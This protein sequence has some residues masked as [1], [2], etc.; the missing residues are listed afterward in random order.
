MSQDTPIRAVNSLVRSRRQF[1][2]L[3]TRSLT[4][5]STRSSTHSLTNLDMSLGSQSNEKVQGIIISLKRNLVAIVEVKDV[6]RLG[7]HRL[8]TVA[9]PHSSFDADLHLVVVVLVLERLALELAEE[10]G[11]Q[12][13]VRRSIRV[14]QVAEVRVVAGNQRQLRCGRVLLLSLFD[15]DH[16]HGETEWWWLGVLQV[17]GG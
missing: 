3:M 6:S 5:S 14:E 13:L 16:S 9:H 7:I 2:S 4:R 15:V 1:A 12:L 10:P 17:V 8:G 11:R